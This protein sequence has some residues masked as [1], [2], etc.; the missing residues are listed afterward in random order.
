[1]TI[2]SPGGGDSSFITFSNTTLTVSWWEPNYFSVNETYTIII[3]ASINNMN[4]LSP[5][6]TSQQF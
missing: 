5:F 4:I 1:M 3:S 6:N 2:T